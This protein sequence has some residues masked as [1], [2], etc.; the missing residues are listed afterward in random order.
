ME[1]DLDSPRQ[2]Y[3]ARSYIKV[4]EEELPRLYS[5]QYTF[6]QDNAPIH[7][8]NT[9]RAWLED[10]G[11]RVLDWPPYSPD[12]NP[13]EHLWWHLKRNVYRLRPD[14]EDLT[15]QQA[16]EALQEVLPEAWRRI[17]WWIFKKCGL[18]MQKRVKA[19]TKAKCWHTK[20]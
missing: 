4:L 10:W 11:I 8:A 1:R 9:T 2:G 6:M 15:R 13:Q 20:Y 19:V 12:L 18:S 5:L 7:A 3:S 16:I 17:P 14:L